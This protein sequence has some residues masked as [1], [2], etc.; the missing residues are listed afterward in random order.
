MEY[1]GHKLYSIVLIDKIKKA[2][3][4]FVTLF[5]QALDNG[6]LMDGQAALPT[7]TTQS[8]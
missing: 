4:K 1:V 7:P 2:S 6:P 3:R 5:L 8:S